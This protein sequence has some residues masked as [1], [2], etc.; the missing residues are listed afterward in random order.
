MDVPVSLHSVYRLSFPYLQDRAYPVTGRL[1]VRW[2]S[3]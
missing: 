2:M 1:V 3:Q